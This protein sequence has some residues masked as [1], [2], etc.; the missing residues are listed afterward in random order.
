MNMEE[1]FQR[2]G[3]E[4][5]GPEAASWE[6][7]YCS[8]ILILVAFFAM[9]VSYATVEG[10]LAGTK[11]NYMRGYGV[12]ALFEGSGKTSEGEATSLV[13]TSG[14]EAISL[15]SK[16]LKHYV[17][18]SRLSQ[19]VSIEKT[20]DGLRIV[21]EDHILFS[22]GKADLNKQ[23]YAHLDHMVEILK[24]HPFSIRIEGHT[25]DI[26]IHTSEFPS[27]WELSIARAVGVLR[28]LLEGGTFQADRLEA[29]GC[30]S[31]NP[32]ASNDS[33]EGRQKNRRVEF[34][35]KLEKDKRYIWQLVKNSF[36]SEG[37]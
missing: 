25:D 28:Y 4:G 1:E 26:P 14:L 12:E 30:S 17:D 23:A 6:S 5:S 21:F 19:S 2:K 33:V 31:Y 13:A 16:A 34:H 9:L 10:E 36:K 8:L 29:V 18:T 22:S 20:A 11:T 7:I 35:V 3:K 24:P 27:N 37:L 32:I 15:T